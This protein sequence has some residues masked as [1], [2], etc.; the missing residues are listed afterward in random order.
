MQSTYYGGK[1][2]GKHFESTHLYNIINYIFVY[3]II[4]V[5][6]EQKR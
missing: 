1:E 4:A 2:V 6:G 5:R 3:S